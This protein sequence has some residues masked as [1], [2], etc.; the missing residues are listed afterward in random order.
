MLQ[1]HDWKIIH[2]K[3]FLQKIFGQCATKNGSKIFLFTGSSLKVFLLSLQVEKN[4]TPKQN[5]G[6]KTSQKR[7][8]GQMFDQNLY[9][10]DEFLRGWEK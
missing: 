9:L 6:S 1:K 5:Q 7:V 4:A 2:F 3:N 8:K 10:S